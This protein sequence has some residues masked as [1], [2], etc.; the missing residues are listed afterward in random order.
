MKRLILLICGL[1]VLPAGLSMAQQA[2]TTAP[3]V[4]AMRP[5]PRVEIFSFASISQPAQNDW[6][7][8]GIQESLQSDVARTGA[9]LLIPIHPAAAN[10]DAV[11]VARE[12]FAQYG[13]S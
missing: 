8:R 11:T 4:V 5:N 2:P 6:I 7:G 9:T 3:A 13:P 12:V 10:D 1:F